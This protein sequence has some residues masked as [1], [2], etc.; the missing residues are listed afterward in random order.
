MMA[1]GPISILPAALLLTVL[2]A[3]HRRTAV[4]LVTRSS[5][6]LVPVR[7]AARRLVVLP[8]AVRLPVGHRQVARVAL[9]VLV[10]RPLGLRRRPIETPG[11]ARQAGAN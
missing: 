9:V 8:L 5:T 2:P 7:V 11:S 1:C 3:V 6:A 10:V 4:R